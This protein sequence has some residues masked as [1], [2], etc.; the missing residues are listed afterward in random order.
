MAETAAPPARAGRRRAPRLLRRLGVLFGTAWRAD[1]RLLTACSAAALGYVLLS[2]AYP[3]GFRAIIDGATQHRGGAV[4]LGVIITVLALPG[5]WVLRLIGAT[6]G[7]KLTDQA[8]LRLGMLIG[9]LVNAA[10]FLEHFE[11]PES[12]AEIDT[13]RERRRTLAA[14]PAQSLGLIRSGLLF[15]GAA[16]LLALVWPPLLVVPLLA[17]APGLADRR[18]GDRE[19]Q[20]RRPGRLPPAAG[21]AVLAGLHGRAGPG[22][23]HVRRQRCAAGP[24][25]PAG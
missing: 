16:A 15:A 20:R 10:P 7:S 3:L 21:R 11:R 13:L 25:R 6:W 23:A 24:A 4:V 9:G 2:L 12:L 22:A 17:A 19:A 8:S 5:S 18:A 14:A 1:P